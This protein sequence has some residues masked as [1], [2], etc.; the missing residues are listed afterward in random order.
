MKTRKLICILFVAA[1]ILAG[2][3]QKKSTTKSTNKKPAPKPDKITTIMKNMT[4]DQKI[5]Q[6]YFAHS[7]GDSTQMLHDVKKYQLGGITLFNPDFQKESEKS[8]KQKMKS[9]QTNSNHGLFIA[10]D[11]EGG[12]VSRLSN[13]A[14][15]QG[16]KFPSPQ[17]VYKKSGL[18][19]IKKEDIAVA[20][21][22][23]RSG[24]NMNFAPVADVAKKR[25]SFIF[26]R[27]LGKNYQTTAQYIPV[28]V[29]AIQ[30]Q[31]VAAVLKHFPGYG[32]AKDT[33]TGFAEI[34]KSLSAYQKED[35]LPFK[36]GIAANVDGV[37]VSHIVIKSLDN[38]LPASL[39]PA[40][41]ELLRD[42]LNYK[43]LIITDDLEM[44]A[45]TQYAQDH[46]INA[47]VL[48]LK[49]GNDL[50]LGGNYK[51]GIPAIKHALKSGEISE[52]QIDN[53]V[54]RILKLKEKLHI[55][56]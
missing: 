28:A 55:L 37:M 31:N 36:A 13:T 38:K 48:A 12:S 18:T 14:L 49:A 50:L 51:T 26:E 15:A 4:L 1:A 20:K 54:Y 17:E 45:I 52:K 43:G 27:T 53:S 33:H 29:K 3:S 24:I 8:F 32:D 23:Q 2:C 5:G 47:D 34:D 16:R 44:G 40:V 25:S 42:K 22:L 9:Y 30:S 6:L 35:L 39:S 46:H 10:T 11:Q 7:T 19:G 21:L 41:H 56:K